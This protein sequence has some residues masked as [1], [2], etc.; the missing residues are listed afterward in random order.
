MAQDVS[1]LR[2]VRRQLFSRIHMEDLYNNYLNFESSYAW[3]FSRV[4]VIDNLHRLVETSGGVRL[5]LF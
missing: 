2:P 5:Q 3:Q 4:T 1:V